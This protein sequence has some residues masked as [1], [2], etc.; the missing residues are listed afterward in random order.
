[1]HDEPYKYIYLRVYSIGHE[2]VQK[3]QL[4]IVSYI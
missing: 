4:A 3:P 2:A 1:M